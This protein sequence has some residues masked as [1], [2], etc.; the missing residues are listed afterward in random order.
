MKEIKW[1]GGVLAFESADE[2]K[3]FMGNNY[4]LKSF[5]LLEPNSIVMRCDFMFYTS[6]SWDF[7]GSNGGPFSKAGLAECAKKARKV[8]AERL[9]KDVDSEE[10]KGVQI[11]LHPVYNGLAYD[12]Y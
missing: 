10:V 8:L 5:L 9:K 11:Y 2:F 1:L 7:I 3:A 12:N 4:P 6:D